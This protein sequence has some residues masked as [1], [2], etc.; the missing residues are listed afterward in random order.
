MTHS[1]F[2]GSSLHPHS[3]NRTRPRSSSIPLSMPPPRPPAHPSPPQPSRPPTP[4][5]G[6]A[7]RGRS[8]CGSGRCADPHHPRHGASQRRTEG[9]SP[10]TAAGVGSRIGHR[11]PRCGHG[12]P[13]ITGTGPRSAPRAPT[14]SASTP[15]ASGQLLCHAVPCRATPCSAMPCRAVPCHAA[16]RGTRQPHPAPP[17]S[18]SHLFPLPIFR[19]INSTAV[20]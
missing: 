12:C 13:P 5:R 11:A 9:L 15:I 10:G 2:R 4:S 8:G 1:S 19:M 18:P 16:G 3:R 14:H 7:D 20:S 6:A 17:F